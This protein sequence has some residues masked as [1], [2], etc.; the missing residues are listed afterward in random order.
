VNLCTQEGGKSC[1]F[2]MLQFNGRERRRA[3]TVLQ[4][5]DSGYIMIR[6]YIKLLAFAIGKSKIQTSNSESGF[7]TIE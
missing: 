1:N 2:T 7:P 4:S 5:N 6:S 3:A